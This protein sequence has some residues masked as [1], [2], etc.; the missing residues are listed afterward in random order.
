[1]IVDGKHTNTDKKKS[2]PELKE[3]ER[4]NLVSWIVD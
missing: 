4:W 2:C 3:L 1:M